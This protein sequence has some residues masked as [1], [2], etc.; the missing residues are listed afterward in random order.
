MTLYN[1]PY[2][3]QRL[4][5]LLD[6]GSYLPVCELRVERV[7]EQEGVAGS[8]GVEPAGGVDQSAVDPL[9][10]GRRL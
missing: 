8:F 4:E 7:V 10:A 1:Y 2:V 9:G 6:P 5:E 3:S